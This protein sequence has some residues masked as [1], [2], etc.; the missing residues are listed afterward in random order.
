MFIAGRGLESPVVLAPS[1]S[2]PTP[3]E[4]SRVAHLDVERADPSQS[5]EHLPVPISIF[6]TQ[7]P[8]DRSLSPIKVK[9]R[10][11]S[12]CSVPK[13]DAHILEIMRK[14]SIAMQL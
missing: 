7:P 11:Y 4:A 1:K 6:Q 3:G 9:R 13:T 10:T 5:F 12:H 14:R 2:A 8:Q